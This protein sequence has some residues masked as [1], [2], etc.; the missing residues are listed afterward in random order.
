LKSDTKYV[1]QDGTAIDNPYDDY[2]IVKFDDGVK[3]CF[4]A[5][6]LEVCMKGVL[7]LGGDAALALLQHCGGTAGAADAFGAALADVANAGLYQA[8]H[9]SL[10]E[11]ECAEAF[12]DAALLRPGRRPR[13]QGLFNKWLNSAADRTAIL[14]D[15]W[16][17]GTLR[18]VRAPAAAEAQLAL[19]QAMFGGWATRVQRTGYGHELVDLLYIHGFAMKSITATGAQVL[20]PL[21]RKFGHVVQGLDFST[22]PFTDGPAAVAALYEALQAGAF[23]QLREL[24]V[25]NNGV[26]ERNLDDLWKYYLKYMHIHD[27]KYGLNR[28][29]NSAM[30]RAS[31]D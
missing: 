4:Q 11:S 21:L 20:L 16:Y 8:T 19:G 5:E 12:C 6:R 3:D 31:T 25:R 29:Q 14:N 17:R 22:G 26:T 9:L 7:L 15:G 2:L 18:L 28:C 30:S 27:A 1:R 24:S 13:T 10:Q 23:P